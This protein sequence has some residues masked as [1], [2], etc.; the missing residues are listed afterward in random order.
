MCSLLIF[1]PHQQRGRKRGSDPSGGEH[2]VAGAAGRPCWRPQQQCA[3]AGGAH[4]PAAA[5]GAQRVAGL[6]PHHPA[7][8]PHF[9][10]TAT[11]LPTAGLLCRQGVCVCVCEFFFFLILCFFLAIVFF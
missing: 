6:Q 4:L 5:G 7:Q 8:H 9:L 1:S 3:H 10:R 11:A 2:F